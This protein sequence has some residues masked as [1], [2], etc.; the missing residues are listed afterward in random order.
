LASGS[1]T[2][3]PYRRRGERLVFT[4]ALALMKN[5]QNQGRIARF[6]NRMFD[7]RRYFTRHVGQRQFQ[8]GF[9]LSGDERDRT[10][11]LLVANQALHGDRNRRKTLL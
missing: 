11:N 8:R 5:P 1:A 2:V 6:F 3:R 4:Q 9:M 7:R 10:A